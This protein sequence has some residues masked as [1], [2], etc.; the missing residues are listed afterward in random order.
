LS[1]SQSRSTPPNQSSSAAQ[2]SLPA[3]DQSDVGA[4]G[5]SRKQEKPLIRKPYHPNPPPHRSE[6]VMWVGNIPADA[7]HDELWKFFNQLPTSSSSSSASSTPNQYPLTDQRRG[8]GVIS[9]FLI[10]KSS[11]VF[12]NYE[13]K[14]HLSQ[15]IE[16]FNGKP[17][18][19]YD[20]KCLRMVCRVRKRDDDL[21]AGVGGQ[22]GQGLHTKWIQDQKLKGKLVPSDVSASTGIF[23]SQASGSSGLGSVDQITAQTADLALSSD[24]EGRHKFRTSHRSSSGSFT[25]TDSSLL[26]AFFPK[27]YFIL[28]SLT[29]VWRTHLICLYLSWKLTSYI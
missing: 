20:P 19:P 6:W 9:I 11:C 23:P 29:Q 1:A 14:E 13:T 10:S 22:R 8:N 7:T 5:T 26:S 12:V 15:G 28:K 4:S 16:R 2:P 25:S 17:L 18:R 21:K 27:R 24:D 3:V